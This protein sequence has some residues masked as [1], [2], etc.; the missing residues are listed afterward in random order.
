MD[1]TPMRIGFAFPK[2]TFASHCGTGTS[3]ES[4]RRALTRFAGFDAICRIRDL[5]DS[6]NNA[7]LGKSPLH[8]AT[9][10]PSRSVKG[11]VSDNV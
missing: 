9:R 5:P 7:E 2:N 4:L 3:E 11:Y 6:S 10:S 1:E 8:S